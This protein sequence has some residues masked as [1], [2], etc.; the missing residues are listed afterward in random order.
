MLDSD[1]GGYRIA[2]F[3]ADCQSKGEDPC[4]TWSGLRAEM[5]D[6]DVNAQLHHWGAY[7]DDDV[8]Y[9]NFA[10]HMQL[11]R[12]FDCG[13]TFRDKHLALFNGIPYCGMC[14]IENLPA[15]SENDDAETTQ[16]PDDVPEVLTPDQQWAA[17]RAS[18]SAQ[19][20]ATYGEA[21]EG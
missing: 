6:A 19:W 18:L 8:D 10:L 15:Y 14:L 21:S 16:F 12:C 5:G 9:F 2:E 3:V 17:V 1:N 7:G 4:E 11:R 20:D 13:E